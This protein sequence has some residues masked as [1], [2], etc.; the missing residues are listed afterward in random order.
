MPAPPQEEPALGPPP[1]AT[2][3]QQNGSK[4]SN[5]YRSRMMFQPVHATQH[6]ISM[7]KSCLYR[8][9]LLSQRTPL[10]IDPDF[11]SSVPLGKLQ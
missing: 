10:G 11:Q 4:H 9:K 3:A 5:E 8:L 7:G 2:R 6:G 1:D